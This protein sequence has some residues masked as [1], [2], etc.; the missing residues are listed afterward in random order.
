MIENI[1][2]YLASFLLNDFFMV[3]LHLFLASYMYPIA[4]FLS[5]LTSKKKT[6]TR[7]CITLRIETTWFQNEGMKT[8]SKT[9]FPFASFA[10]L[11]AN[12]LLEVNINLKLRICIWILCR[13]RKHLA[14]WVMFDL[15]DS[16]YLVNSLFILA[17]SHNCRWTHSMKGL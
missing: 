9:C 11:L 17:P 10:R 4:S 3:L 12:H 1:S 2:L 15:I 6:L 8:I 5:L 16:L 13:V 7:E 14:N